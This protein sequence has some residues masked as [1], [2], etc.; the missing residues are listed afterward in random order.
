MM[1]DVYSMCEGHV[2]WLI[3]PGNTQHVICFLEYQL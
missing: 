3:V 2:F 1:V